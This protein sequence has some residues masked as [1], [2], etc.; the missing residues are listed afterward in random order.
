MNRVSIFSFMSCR[1]SFVVV[2]GLTSL[3]GCQTP[4]DDQTDVQGQA[5]RDRELDA[6]N[7]DKEE[8]EPESRLRACSPGDQKKTTIC[9]VPPGN[10]SNAHTLCVG[11]SAVSAHLNHGDY[12]GVCKAEL[13]CPTPSDRDAELAACKIEKD[14]VGPDANLR[15]CDANNKK[16]TTICHIPPGNP[17]NAHTLCV[18]NAAV[19]AHVRHGDVV[20]PCKAEV[21]C[22]TPT[23]PSGTGGASGDGASGTSGSGG[24]TGTAPMPTGGAGGGEPVTMCKPLGAT[25]AS[26]SEC[27]HNFCASDNTCGQIVL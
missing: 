18:G 25:C 2:V 26:D 10:P 13:A 8:I 22:P 6:C 16:K 7:I 24:S 11:N 21:A 27:C 19:A 4:G 23:P 5:Q 17:G 15:A 12:L 20:G 3:L 9:H 14:D 1:S